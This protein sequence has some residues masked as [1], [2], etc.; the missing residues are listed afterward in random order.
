MILALGLN[1]TLTCQLF[2]CFSPS[3]V[4]PFSAFSTV[5]VGNAFVFE[6]LTGVMELN[7]IRG[8]FV[9]TSGGRS[10]FTIRNIAAFDPSLRLRLGLELSL[11]FRKELRRLLVIIKSKSNL[12]P[13][14]NLVRIS[15]LLL[16]SLII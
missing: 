9:D 3:L 1:L 6:F 14:S 11:G 13:N 7:R 12:D 16:I 5:S 8:T 10:G 2:F 4:M 15:G